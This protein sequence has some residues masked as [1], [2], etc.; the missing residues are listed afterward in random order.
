[1]SQPSPNTTFNQMT[2]NVLTTFGCG[3]D[4]TRYL[5]PVG[6]GCPLNVVLHRDHLAIL[7][8]RQDNQY[9]F[10]TIKDTYVSRMCRVAFVC[11]FWFIEKHMMEISTASLQEQERIHDNELIAEFMGVQ[12]YKTWAEMEAVP[13]EKLSIWTLIE[14]LDYHK[15]WSSLMPVVEKISQ[16]VYEQ[17]EIDEITYYDRAHVRTFTVSDSGGWMVRFNRSPLYEGSTLIEATYKAVVDWIRWYNLQKS[18]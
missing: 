2:H 13:I 7:R 18:A 10:K 14:K 3:P 6:I 17:N 11:Y 5:L 4:G 12:V 8:G 15:S 1:M 9:I 16:H